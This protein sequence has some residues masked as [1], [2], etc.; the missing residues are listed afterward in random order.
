LAPSMLQVFGMKKLTKS[1][2]NWQEVVLICRKCT[3]KVGGGFGGKGR[4]PLA[5]I[6]RKELGIGRGR[7]A[8]IGF[9]EIGCLDVCPKR[10][11]TVVLGSRPGTRFVV[12]AGM[13]AA[14]IAT[15]LELRQNGRTEDA[16]PAT[17]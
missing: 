4:K 12:P 3:R 2:A 16:V 10:A 6:L 9:L 14:E 8:G 13:A 1:K 17:R 5:R 15:S 7:R 11:V